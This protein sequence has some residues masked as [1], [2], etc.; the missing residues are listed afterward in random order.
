MWLWLSALLVVG[1]SIALALGGMLLVRR[2]VG[3]AVLERHNEVAGFIYAVMG[4]L[5][6]VLLAFVV[7]IVWERHAEAQARAEQEANELGDLFRNAQAYPDSIREQLQAQIR[8]YTSLVATDEW[9]SMARGRASARAWTTFNELWQTYLSFT[10]STAKQ[11]LWHQ[12]SLDRL[13]EL[14]DYRRLRLLS[15]RSALPPLMWGVLIILGTITLAFSY[16][17]GTEHLWAQGVMT[18]ALASTLALILFLIAA[19]QHP[20]SGFVQV[21]P[22]AFEQLLSIFDQWMRS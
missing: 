4:V 19:L 20:F 10:P 18:A 12:E 2:S 17:F 22:E 13:D 6:A 21:R 15:S 14:G 7:I 16:L 5:Y 9:A 3:V 11:T 1:G 8:T